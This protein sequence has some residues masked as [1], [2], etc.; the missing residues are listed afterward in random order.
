MTCYRGD[1]TARWPLHI[2]LR[3]GSVSRESTSETRIQIIQLRE[4]GCVRGSERR[5]QGRREI[6]ADLAGRVGGGGGGAHVVD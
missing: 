1:R 4:L 5:E 6:G 3:S 2:P